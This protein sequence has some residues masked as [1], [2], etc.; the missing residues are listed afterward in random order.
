M[1][2]AVVV[3]FLDVLDMGI[4]IS[5]GVAVVTVE[6]IAVVVDVVGPK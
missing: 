5:I 4:G 1:L 2:V 3:T 6:L